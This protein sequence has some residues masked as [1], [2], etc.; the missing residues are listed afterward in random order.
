MRIYVLVLDG[1]FDSGLSLVLD[2]FSTANELAALFSLDA[3][4]FELTLVGVASEVRSGQG[5]GIPLK[6]APGDSALEQPDLVVIPAVACK[7]PEQLQAYLARPQVAAAAELLRGWAAAGARIAAACIGTFI[8]AESGLLDGKAATTTWWLSPLFR[9]RYP[10]VQLD[11]DTMVIASGAV[12]TAGAALA[13]MDLMLKLIRDVN[14]RL[15]QLTANYLV[16]DTRPSQ[17][18]YAMVDHLAHADPLLLRFDQ[19]VRDTLSAGFSLPAAAAALATSQRTL[20]R[21]ITVLTGKT[22]LALVQDI[23][24]HKTVHLLQTS[25]QSVEEIAAAVGY[26]DGVTL[27]TLLRRRLGRGVKELRPGLPLS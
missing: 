24:I 17:V 16:V 21:R 1:V 12:L 27:R 2:A 9:K 3:P 14:P 6:P 4:R 13:H 26:A 25:S 15:A 10:K 18:A 23:R 22:P 20:S 11:M 7:Q 5:F 8:L 19:Y